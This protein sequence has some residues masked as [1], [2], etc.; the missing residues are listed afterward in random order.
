MTLTNNK[1][2][3]W[4][5]TLRK[6]C[7]LA[8]G[9]IC[10]CCGESEFGFLTIDHINGGGRRHRKNTGGGSNYLREIRKLGFPRGFRVLCYNCNNAYNSFG[11]CPHQKE[12]KNEI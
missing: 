7:I 10:A 2:S 6:D 4:Y 5:H 9:G 3:Q 8:Y 11:Y 1:A 12:H